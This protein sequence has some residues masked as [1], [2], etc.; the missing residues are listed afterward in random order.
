MVGTAASVKA[1]SFQLDTTITVTSSAYKGALN[2]GLQTFTLKMDLGNDSIVM[3]TD[4]IV[5]FNTAGEFE[6]ADHGA[7]SGVTYLVGYKSFD[8]SAKL[9]VDSIQINAPLI[10][11][12][13]GTP[14]KLAG[15]TGVYS[16]QFKGTGGNATNNDKYLTGTSV[17]MP[18]LLL[19]MFLLLS[20]M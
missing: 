8:G 10:T 13:K 12:S 5:R 16:L 6:V 2:E 11:I 3:T 19:Y 18:K 20:S 7:G 14:V 9:V 17:L 15:G 4:S 1:A